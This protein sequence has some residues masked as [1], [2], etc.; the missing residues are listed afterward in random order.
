[1]TSKLI[2]DEPTEPQLTRAEAST[3]DS[4]LLLEAYSPDMVR[5]EP[6]W[7][8]RH[9]RTNYAFLVLAQGASAVLAFASIWISTRYLGPAGYG[10][11]VAI[12]AASLAVGYLTVNWTAASLS[13]Y[14]IEEFVETG[15][16][17]KTFWTRFLI[18]APNLLLVLAASPLWL[19]RVASWLHL[20]TQAY[21]L[22][23]SHIITQ[24]LWIQVQQGL[25]GAKLMRWQGGLQALE[26][27][28]IFL[29]L[30]VVALSGMASL[31]S[32][33][34]AYIL[35]PLA[36]CIVGL[37]RLRRLIYP[38]VTFDRATLKRLIVFSVPLFPSSFIG[39]FSSNYLDAFFI[40]R[41]LSVA[42]LGVYSVAYQL[43]GTVLQLPLLAGSLLLPL[44][45]TLQTKAPGERL[46]RFLGE[47]LPFLTLTWSV[48]C[49]SVAAVASYFVPLVFGPQF[50]ESATLLWPL[51][52]NAALAAPVLMGYFPISNAKATTY[53]T[54][55]NATISA[56]L[57]VA[58]DLILIPL[59][60]LQGCAWATVIAFLASM[61]VTAYLVGRK[62]T[63][64]QTW[65][66][67]ATLP[68]LVGASVS[69][70]Y[71][72]IAVAW[73]ASMLVAALLVYQYRR[74]LAGGVAALKAVGAFDRLFIMR[75]SFN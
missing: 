37:V 45:V 16:I 71:P 24:A 33:T 75:R 10:G 27:A 19:P 21:P 47:V 74:S 2:S 11:V 42:A 12:I 53:I 55:V 43:S 44:F 50:R 1:M 64:N 52:A 40:T 58:L 38:G 68:A 62:V 46:A 14:G 23:I 51:M 4:A 57:N 60:G 36:M 65:A 26:R 54:F 18:L 7:D 32:V 67:L 70:L 63:A 17:A 34:L 6:G 31:V 5:R 3:S 25:Q 15:K 69:L 66:P 8:L 28:L 13:R 72:S 49:V 20:S 39:Y 56:S 29:I 59:Y 9:G 35:V 22:I 30:L 73:A 48:I 41:F 61:I